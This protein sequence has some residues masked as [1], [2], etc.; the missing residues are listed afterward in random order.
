[1]ALVI[2]NGRWLVA[3]EGQNLVDE[4]EVV[5]D[6]DLE[7]RVGIVVEAVL[8]VEVRRTRPNNVGSVHHRGRRAEQPHITQHMELS[9]RAPAYHL[10]VYG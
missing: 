4:A 9:R 7:R 2:R 3:G 8:R 1:M 6:Q 10:L 5:I